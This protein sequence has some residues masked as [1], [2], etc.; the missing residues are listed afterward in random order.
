MSHTRRSQNPSI[1][2]VLG[3]FAVG[4]GLVVGLK[5]SVTVDRGADSLSVRAKEEAAPSA[6]PTTAGKRS[7][8]DDKKL[9]L[10]RV[11][12]T[13]DATFTLAV[14]DN[15]GTNRKTIFTST[16]PLSQTLTIPYNAWSPDDKLVFLEVGSVGQSPDYWVIRADGES[17]TDGKTYLDVGQYWIDREVPYKI[18]T[19]TGWASETLLIVYTYTDTMEKG[20]HYWFDVPSRTFI[21]LYR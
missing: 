15:D 5:R 17:F 20:P 4:A 9:W 1:L 13:T 19:A 2:L 7:S 10:T 18:R 6:I 12:G 21:Q 11:V 8:N 16:L 14:S 3:L